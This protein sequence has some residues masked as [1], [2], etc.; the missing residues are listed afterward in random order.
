MY[1]DAS[2]YATDL[3]QADRDRAASRRK[4]TLVRTGKCFACMAP[5]QDQQAIVCDED[6]RE[7][8]ERIERAQRLQGY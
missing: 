6:C 7:D 1:S 3:E 2:D 8:W 4:P 5:L